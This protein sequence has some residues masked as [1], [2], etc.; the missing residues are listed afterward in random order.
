MSMMHGYSRNFINFEIPALICL[1]RG[2]HFYTL[3]LANEIYQAGGQGF[4]NV[5]ADSGRQA[6]GQNGIHLG[7]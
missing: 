6:P 5:R 3:R 2:A 7:S 4:R 1:N